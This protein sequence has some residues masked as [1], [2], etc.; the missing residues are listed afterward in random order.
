MF[1]R[2]GIIIYLL[3]DGVCIRIN[4]GIDV[5]VEDTARD[6][7]DGGDDGGGGDDDSDEEEEEEDEEEEEHICSLF[8]LHDP[9]SNR[10]MVDPVFRY[11]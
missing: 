1:D 6:I 10:V 2:L 5:A 4:E 3:A 7:D 9:K 11:T 8:E